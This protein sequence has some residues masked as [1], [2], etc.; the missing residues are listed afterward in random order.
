MGHPGMGGYQGY[1]GGAM[2]P[3]MMGGFPGAG[4]PAPGG[5]NP[6]GMDPAIMGATPGQPNCK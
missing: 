6:L 1:G 4:V 3:S 2:D 5:G